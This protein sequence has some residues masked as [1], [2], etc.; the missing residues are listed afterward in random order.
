M[1][2]RVVE[3][4]AQAALEGAVGRRRNQPRSLGTQSID[5]FQDDRRFG[6]GAL[7]R[8]IAQYWELAEGPKVYEVS[9][10]CVV[11]QIDD[12]FSEGD[13]ELIQSDE[14][15]PTKG[16]ERVEMERQNHDFILLMKR[17]NAWPQRP[18]Q[19]HAHP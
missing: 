8:V 13:L 4:V 18:N 6:Y 11:R 10:R 14:R 2:V 17:L 3:A 5:V 7:L 1:N 12:V 16:G 9:S 19:R 15:L